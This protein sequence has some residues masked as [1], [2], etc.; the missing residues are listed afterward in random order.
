[1]IRSFIAIDLPEPVRHRLERYIRDLK[2]LRLDARFTRAS[3]LHLTLRFLGNID[4]TQVEPLSRTLARSV[5]GFAPF[6][7]RLKGLGTFPTLSRPRVLWVGIDES[8]ELAQLHSAIGRETARLGF[9]PGGRRFRPHLTLARFRSPRGSEA[10]QSRIDAS[11]DW[12]NLSFDVDAVHLFRSDL[13]PTGAVYTK[14][15]S[16]PFSEPD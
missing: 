14:L 15:Y 5:E 16:A 11:H 8:R 2:S 4:E 13:K 12:D 6:A 1:M 7:L 3:A 10:L 9:S